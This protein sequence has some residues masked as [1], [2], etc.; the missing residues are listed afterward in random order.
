MTERGREQVRMKIL[1]YAQLTVRERWEHATGRMSDRGASA[2]E[3]VVITAATAALIALVF[4]AVN[5][6]TLEKINIIDGS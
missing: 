3:W 4:T 2:F 5:G 1:I 6:K